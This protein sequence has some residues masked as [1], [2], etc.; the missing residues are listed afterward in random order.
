[1]ACE[2]LRSLS[3]FSPPEHIGLLVAFY[4]LTL[5]AQHLLQMPQNPVISQPFA[6]AVE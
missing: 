4:Q 1:V 6:A 3:H 2:L 5:I